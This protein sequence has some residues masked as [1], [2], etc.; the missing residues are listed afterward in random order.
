MATHRKADDLLI[1]REDEPF[2]GGAE[3]ADAR[4]HLTNGRDVDFH[5]PQ[6]QVSS[7]QPIVRDA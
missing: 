2:V 5:S 4:I 3:P 6:L 1:S 7:A